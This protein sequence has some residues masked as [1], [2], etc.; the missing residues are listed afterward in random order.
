MFLNPPFCGFWQMYSDLYLP[1]E[2]PAERFH[3]P[4]IALCSACS[5]LFLQPQPLAT[6]NLF[7]VFIVLPFSESHIVG[8]IK[9]VNFSDWLLSLHNIQI[10]KVLLCLFM[11]WWLIS[12][13]TLN[14]TPLSGCASSLD[15]ITDVAYVRPRDPDCHRAG[16][17]V[18]VRQGQEW[19]LGAPTF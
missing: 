8:V 7:I 11:T 12:F 3:C 19:E 15:R 9:N 10:F 2:Y 1:Q 14:D 4:K 5:S 6:T 18:S 16:S 17:L 13:S